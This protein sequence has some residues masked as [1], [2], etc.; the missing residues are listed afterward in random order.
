[1][2]AETESASAQAEEAS[3]YSTA[4]LPAV[5]EAAAVHEAASAIQEEIPVAS[6]AE[7]DET[8][9]AEEFERRV[10][11]TASPTWSAEEAPWEEHFSDRRYCASRHRAHALH[12]NCRDFQ[13]VGRDQ[14]KEVAARFAKKIAEGDTALRFCFSEIVYCV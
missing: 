3:N 8:I 5:E 7:A 14:E 2:E 13:G 11:A 1:A 10:G 4:E 9:S 6:S 12:A